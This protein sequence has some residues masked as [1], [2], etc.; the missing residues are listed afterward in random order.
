[1]RPTTDQGEPE[2]ALPAG[3]NGCT[4]VA[5]VGISDITPGLHGNGRKWEQ[6]VWA[7]NAD[8]PEEA[9]RD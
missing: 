9:R 6:V 3:H 4:A 8:A 7:R 1:M 2:L 5:K